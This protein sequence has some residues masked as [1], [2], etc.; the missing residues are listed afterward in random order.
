MVHKAIN[1]LSEEDQGKVYDEILSLSE[2]L[3]IGLQG[4]V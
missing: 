3:D 2:K 4:L 1:A